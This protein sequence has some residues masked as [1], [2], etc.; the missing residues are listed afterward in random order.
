MD[1]QLNYTPSAAFQSGDISGYGGQALTLQT[2]RNSSSVLGEVNLPLL[3]S[4]ETDI[5]VRRDQYPN[6]SSTNPKISFRYQPVSQALVRASWGKGF[7]EGSLPELYNPQT[8]GTT[9]FIKDPA[10]GVSNQWNETLGG[11]PNLKPER[12]EQ[13]SIGLVLDPVKGL[14]MSIDYW[15]I[16]VRD[17][18]TTLGASAVI[19]GNYAGDPAYAGMVTRDGSGTITNIMN[20]NVNAGGVKVAGIDL[21]VRWQFLKSADYGTYT[22]HLNGTYLTKYDETLPDGSVQPSIGATYLPD[23][24]ETALTAVQNGGIIFRW[25]H[26]LTL[27]WQYKQFGLSLTQNYQSGYRDAP[28][29][30]CS[31]CDITEQVRHGS[32]QTW[33]LQGTYTGIKNLTLRAGVKNLFNKLPPIDYNAGLYFQSG[34]DPTYYDAHGMFGYLTATY[35][36]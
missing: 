25:R 22:A 27:D 14:S 8:F 24:S 29:A 13:S 36:F 30:D 34:Y 31:V 1:E 6:V 20:T 5:A 21:D 17:L 2:S 16:N 35:K 12:S 15:K 19:K 7:R 32:F 9:A 11:N 3:K 28:R 18:I 4:L 26:Q 33:D 10:N 23:D